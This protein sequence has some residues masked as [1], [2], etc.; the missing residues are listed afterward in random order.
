MRNKY[1]KIAMTEDEAFWVK[2]FADNNMLE[3]VRQEGGI[4]MDKK[5]FGNKTKVQKK[6]KAAARRQPA[7]K[8]GSERL[9]ISAMIGYGIL[10][11]IPV[12]GL[13]AAIVLVLKKGRPERSEFAIA[14]LVLRIFY[15]V[16][17]F[18]IVYLMVD[19]VYRMAQSFG[20]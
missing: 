16:F 13:I 7:G 11:A 18:A 15:M 1:R 14:C 8:E 3:P 9:K 20:L 2:L 6:Q 19:L 5:N 17:S 12:I 10:I 4:S